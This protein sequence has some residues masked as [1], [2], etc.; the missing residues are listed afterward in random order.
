MMNIRL[1]IVMTLTKIKDIVFAE[2][3][4][5]FIKNAKQM[6]VDSANQFSKIY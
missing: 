5:I 6:V 4:V 3:I 1:Q 2:I